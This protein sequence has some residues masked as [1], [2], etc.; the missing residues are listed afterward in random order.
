MS[1]PV[2]KEHARR[3]ELARAL[4][5]AP[6]RVG[7]ELGGVVR[8][9]RLVGVGG[10]AYVYEAQR[11]DDGARVAVKCLVP[12]LSNDAVNVTRFL[13]EAEAT[14]RVRSPNVVRI[15]ETSSGAADGVPPYFV[16]EYLEGRDLGAELAESG[17]LPV[18]R[19]VDVVLQAC[20]GVAA[21]HA[22]GIVHRDI[23]PSNLIRCGATIKVVDFGIAKS[24]EGDGGTL[25][26][27]SDTFGSPRYMSPEQV[28]STKRVDVRTD[29]WSLGVVL[30]E[31][32]SGEVP[33]AGDTAGAILAAIVADDPPPLRPRV[34][35]VSPG[36]EA[37]VLRCLEKDR[38]RR[39]QSVDELAARLR[40]PDRRPGK[41]PH[42][43]WLRLAL[44]LGLPLAVGAGVGGYLLALR[45]R[46]APQRTSTPVVASAS[47]VVPAPDDGEPPVVSLARADAPPT[48]APSHVAPPVSSTAPRFKPCTRDDQCGPF[49]KCYPGGCSCKSPAIRCGTTCRIPGTTHDDCGCGVVCGADH[50]C[51]Q[52]GVVPSCEPCEPGHA[53]CGGDACIDL[54]FSMTNCGACGH[55]CAAGAQCFDGACIPRVALG[56]ACTPFRSCQANMRCEE[57]RCECVPGL[58]P[59]RGACISAECTER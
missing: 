55:V 29:V 38:E 49:E 6:L 23:K 8:I 52:Y 25:T 34:P 35:G 33:F 1:A 56:G 22:L 41:R 15:F 43:G 19:A 21:A 27:T 48:R 32:L 42:R 24:L 28:R 50:V 37:I 53:T 51:S 57:S 17:P 13:R 58:H 7:Q 12:A 31:L 26:E 10:M 30:Y 14:S 44:A 11:L 9:G 45:Y 5:K 46:A 4:A 40:N 16:M 2:D 39:T 47:N 36:L 59:C 20:A 54:R 18:A 3:L